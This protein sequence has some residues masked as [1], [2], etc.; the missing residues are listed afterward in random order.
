MMKTRNVFF[1]LKEKF[2]MKNKNFP[3]GQDWDKIVDD[4]FRSNDVHTFS[5]NYLQR[6]A[7]LQKG[8]VMKKNVKNKNKTKMIF[9]IYF[10]INYYLLYTHK[11]KNYFWL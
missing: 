9:F 1:S 3:S 2:Q 6:K 5:D 10:L 8:F 11:L 4:A 7:S